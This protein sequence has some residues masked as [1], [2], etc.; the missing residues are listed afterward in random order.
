AYYNSYDDK[1]HP[2]TPA[3]RPAPTTLYP[4]SLHDAL[5]ICEHCLHARRLHHRGLLQDAACL[6]GS[7]LREPPGIPNEERGA[8]E[9]GRGDN[10]DER[11]DGRDGGSQR[12]GGNLPAGRDLRIRDRRRSFPVGSRGTFEVAQAEDRCFEPKG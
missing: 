12:D 11:A 5:P 2:D 1:S 8:T 6:R 7:D 9:E 4:L 10:G 3:N